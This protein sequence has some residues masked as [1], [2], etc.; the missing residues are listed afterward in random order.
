MCFL[1][2]SKVF[3]ISSKKSRHPEAEDIWIFANLVLFSTQDGEN[4]IPQM[5]SLAQETRTAVVIRRV[6]GVLKGWKILKE[7]IYIY[8]KIKD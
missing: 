1:Y 4:S 6:P 2:S 8:I 7:D 3:R 5:I